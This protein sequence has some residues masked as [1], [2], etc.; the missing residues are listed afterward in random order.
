[1]SSQPSLFIAFLLALALSACGED[2]APTPTT[3]PSAPSAGGA[4]NG[5]AGAARQ[6][7]GP[8]QQETA[9]AEG[10]ARMAPTPGTV[11][12]DTELKDKPFIDAKTLQRL[13]AQ[14]RV[15]I[16]DRSGGWLKVVH[17]GRQGWAR[18]LH[19]G[20][21]PAASASTAQELESAAKIATGRAG[22]GNIVNTTGIRGLS[23]EQLR[24]AKPN[25]AEL[26][27]LESYGVDEE[28]AAEYARKHKL[29]R[30]EIAY[31]PEPR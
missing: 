28:Q 9:A 17:D 22:S 29:E 15:T 26:Q 6:S 18:L 2:Q 11:L 16:V 3:A 13:P 1:M 25:P 27:R 10:S 5:A 8:R 19:V 4:P 23:E 7:A 20:S 12:R 21:Q 24:E 31:L 30:R 14:T